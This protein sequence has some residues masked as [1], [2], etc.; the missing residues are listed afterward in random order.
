MDFS[1]IKCFENGV[2]VKDVKNFELTHIF[3]CGQ[4]FRWHKQENGNYIGVVYGRVIEIEKKE[5]DVIIYNTNEEDFKKIWIDYFDLN[6]DYSKIKDVLSKDPILS[7]SVNFGYGIRLLKQDPFEIIVSFIISANNR[8]PMI[9]REIENISSNWG[10]RLEYKGNTYY[11]FPTIEKLSSVSVEELENCGVGFRAKYIKN[12]VNNIYIKGDVKNQEYNEEYDINWIK[13]QEAEKCHKEL[14][15]FMGIGPKVADCIML[16]SMEKYSAFPVDVWVKR[17]M[18]YFYLAPDVSLKKIRDFG[19]SKF[20]D[21]AGFAQQYLFYY[22][23][24][25]G[26]K[27]DG[28]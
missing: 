16:F 2:I 20:N 22:A 24:E 11:S 5:N 12:T 15:N 7:T 14:Q 4:C 27:F 1:S 21:L 9:K 8:I 19:V 23:R 25:N 10:E 3:D 6:R 17:A 28:D 13:S 26:I 18:Q